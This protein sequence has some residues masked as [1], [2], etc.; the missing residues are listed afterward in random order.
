MATQFDTQLHDAKRGTAERMQPYKE[1][2]PAV[3]IFENK[4]EVLILADLPGVEKDDLAIQFEK[5]HLSLQ[6]KR[7]IE[8]DTYQYVRSFVVPNGIDA[9][10]IAAELTNGVLRLKLP[11][12]AALKPRTIAVKTG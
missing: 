6:A 5:N 1:L 8:G 7:K 4:E 10:K 3:D 12:S 2:T 11:K 9:E